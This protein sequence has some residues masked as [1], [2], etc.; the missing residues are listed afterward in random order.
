ML[1]QYTTDTAIWKECGEA[2][3]YVR[4]LRSLAPV[5]LLDLQQSQERPP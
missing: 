2:P 4:D 5:N 1:N 3:S